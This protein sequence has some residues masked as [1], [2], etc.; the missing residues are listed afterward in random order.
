MTS[1]GEAPV[2]DFRKVEYHLIAITL[3]QNGR[4]GSN[5]TVQ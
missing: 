5:R 2:L 1:G 3:S 4:S